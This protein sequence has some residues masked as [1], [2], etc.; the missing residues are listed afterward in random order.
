ME[1]PIY[2]QI[3]DILRTKIKEQEANTPILSER[4]LEKRY[5]ASRMTVRKAV[6]MLVEEGI[7]YRIQNVGTFVADH[8]LHKKSNKQ[9]VLEVFAKDKEYKII[10]FNIKSGQEDINQKLEI[11]NEDQYVRI[12]R[13]NFQDGEPESVDE[14]YI[15]RKMIEEKGMLDIHSVLRFSEKLDCG[16]VNQ[17]FIPMMVPIQYSNLLKVKI[18]TPIIRIDS[19]I[20]TK[21]GRVYAFVQSYPHPLKKEIEITI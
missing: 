10:Y 14:V 18:G 11:D 1:K 12:V 21:N 6:D 9:Q 8:K 13:L 16:A 19:K 17:V 15:V 2:Q 3:M 5:N 7:L 4:E 20:H